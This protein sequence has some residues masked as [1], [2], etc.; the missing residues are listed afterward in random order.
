VFVINQASVLIQN[1]K[2]FSNLR[3]ESQ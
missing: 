2:I 3:R 1:Q